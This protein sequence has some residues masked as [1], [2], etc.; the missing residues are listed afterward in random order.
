MPPIFYNAGTVEIE[1]PCFAG[2]H[3]A[4]LAASILLA[5]SPTPST[6]ISFHVSL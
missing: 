1:S 5:V 4:T 2:L 6:P 3:P